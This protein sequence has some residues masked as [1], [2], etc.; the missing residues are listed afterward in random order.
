VSETFGTIARN[1]SEAAYPHLRRGLVGAW[2]PSLG[3]TGNTLRDV[4]GRGNHGV[5][6]DMDAATDWQTSGGGFLDF[7]GSNDYVLLP[8]R[9]V[10]LPFSLSIWFRSANLTKPYQALFTANTDVNA[11]PIYCGVHYIS[12]SSRMIFYGDGAYTANSDP[13]AQ[14]SSWHH[15]AWSVQLGGAGQYFRDG[16]Q[17]GAFARNVTAKPPSAGSIG[18]SRA[19]LANL[20]AAQ[21]AIAECSRWERVLTAAEIK[22]VYQSGPGGWLARK[23]RRVY[24]VTAAPV[25]YGQRLSRHRTILGG[26]L[27]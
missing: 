11:P 2:V 3:V 1:A 17:I 14:D 4:S 5:L 6:T 10:E 9:S 21:G 24:S 25:V 23:R 19:S 26:G 16:V 27:R 12:G 7:D 15:Y 22:T 18:A 8:S 13:F 20:F